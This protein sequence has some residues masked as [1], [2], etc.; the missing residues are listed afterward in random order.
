MNEVMAIWADWLR[1]SAGL[2]TVQW[3]LLL[4]VAAAI[5]HLVQR[6]T[7]VPKVVGYSLTGAVA[8]LAGFSGG[9]WPIEGIALFL[10]ELGV[11]VVLF[12]AGGRLALRWFRHNPMVL[13]Q[14]L[15]ESMLTAILVYYA[16][17]ALGVTRGVAEAVGLIS[18]SASP[19]VL[20][21]V[22]MDT[23]ASGPVTER[24]LALSTLS[25]LYALTLVNA[26]AG[27]MHHASTELGE[28]LFPVLV[29]LGVSCVVAGVLALVLR[30]ALR[31]MSPTSENTSMLLIASIAAASTIASHF[32][33]SAP[34]AALLAGLLLKLLNP[35]PWAW[36]RQL[37]TASSLLTML[38]FVLVSVVASKAPWNHAVVGIVGTIVLTRALAKIAGVSAANWGSGTSLKQ[39]FWTGCTLSPMS[40]VALLMV[41][42]YANTTPEL[43][44]AITSI[45]LPAILLMEVLGAMIA[46]FALHRARET[47][48]ADAPE[49]PVALREVRG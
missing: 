25:A 15:L 31:F 10:L 23:R 21:R 11:A 13:L 48:L 22:V 9:A 2:P 17:R 24:A 49:G 39:A 32:G 34:L 6:H 7:G 42:Q 8:G 28:M 47:S 40:S 46:T 5:G 1:P 29:V 35:R 37:G 3:S 18:M 19:A 30:M 16:L 14:S 41:S 33:G 20:S 26:R 44:P 4:A 27:V 12:E 38:M 45:A 43:A 36:P